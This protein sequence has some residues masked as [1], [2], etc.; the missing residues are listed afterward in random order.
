MDES[1]IR[2]EVSEV[3]YSIGIIPYHPPDMRPFFKEKEGEKPAEKEE[4]KERRQRGFGRIDLIGAN[5]AG[6]TVLVEVKDLVMADGPKMGHNAILYFK[7]ISKSQRETMDR[8]VYHLLGTG[9]LAIGTIENGSE[10]R[11][12]F[13]IPWDE[14]AAAELELFNQGFM[15]MPLISTRNLGISNFFERCELEWIGTKEK[16]HWKFPGYHPILKIK[17]GVLVDTQYDPISLRF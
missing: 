10:K 1:D 14:W 17:R 8:W 12:L 7:E 16:V 9:F 11:R 15:G 3:L 13:I 5:P 4:K 6:E 2:N